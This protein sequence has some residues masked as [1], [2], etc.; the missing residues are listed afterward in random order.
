MEERVVCV[1]VL[2]LCAMAGDP[3]PH[4]CPSVAASDVLAFENNLLG[5]S[6]WLR[7]WLR[8]MAEFFVQFL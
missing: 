8:T 4:M 2:T 3:C 6:P 1:R 7:A 5:I